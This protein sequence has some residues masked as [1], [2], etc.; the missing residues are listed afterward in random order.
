MNYEVLVVGAGFAGA[1]ISRKM[2]ERGKKVLLIDKRPHIAG[3]MYECY[4]TN[5]V[6]IHLYGPH[7]FHT[8]KKNVFEFL[9]KF[10]EF[11]PYDHKVIGNIDGQLV[12]IPFNYKSLEIL[13]EK[14]KADQIKEVLN[15]EFGENT[16]VSIL[17][18]INH[19]NVIIKEFGKYV[20]QKVF[21]EYTAKQWEMPVDKIDNSVINRVPVVLGYDDRYFS[22][23]F[24]YMP[25]EGFTSI[26]ENMLDHE[27]IT[28]K[29]N[30]NALD[31]LK[32]DFENGKTFVN[33]E[34]F[35]GK[36]FFTGAVDELLNYQY[37]ALP[38]RSL[39]LVFEQ[40][41]KDYYQTNSVVNYNTSEKFTRITEFKYLTNQKLDHKT[42]ILKEYPL[43]YDYQNTKSDPYY[44][45]VQKENLELYNQYVN[46][47]AN[48]KNFYL[49][50]RLAEYK[51][52]NMD[53]VIDRALNLV[54]EVEE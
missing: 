21:A 39:N 16:K 50:G 51:Y 37:G 44:P 31:I 7:I 13:F 15:Q 25:K 4:D 42:T 17:D 19:N 40:Y 6:R 1:T 9:K 53:A 23:Q 12:P 29:L 46:D 3:N 20:Y 49:C 22:D 32:L 38:Y 26:I 52:Y 2:A 33:N 30:T 27:N 10:G 47:L 43:K 8:S 5:G 48:I 18:L 28:I 11:Y 54:E 34:E 36:V 41:D 35:H 14:E 45:I 24:Q